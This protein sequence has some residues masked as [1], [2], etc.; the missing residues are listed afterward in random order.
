MSKKLSHVV[1]ENMVYLPTEEMSEMAV[2]NLKEKL[3]I[4]NRYNY[5]DVLILYDDTQI[6]Y[7]G[8]PLYYW[9]N[10]DIVA[11]KIIDRRI[12]GH[13]VSFSMTTTPKP[14]QA[15]ILGLFQESL[16]KGETGL[17]VNAPPGWGKTRT[18]IE[19]LQ[20]LG[21]RAL[22]VVPKSDLVDQWVQRIVD[23]TSLS[24]PEIGIFSGGTA[25]YYP[26]RS[27]ISIGLVHTLALERFHKYAKEFG[28]V[29][30]DEVHMSVPPKTFAPVA[31]LFAPKYRIGASATLDRSDGWEKAFEY[32]IEQVR[33]VGDAST[34]R[35]PAT[36]Y[37]VDFNKSSGPL[38]SWVAGD[39]I[40]TR[41]VLISKFAE[42]RERTNF[43][44]QAAKRSEKSGRRT[45]IISDRTSI[46]VDVY[47]ILTNQLGYEKEEVGFYCSSLTSI[48]GA[49]IRT[50]KKSEQAYTAKHAKIILSTY[51]L[52]STGTDIPDMA[53]IILATPQSKVTQT[54]G[55][56]ERIFDGK[57]SPVVMDIVDSFYEP[58]RTWSIKRHK[59]YAEAEMQIKKFNYVSFLK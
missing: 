45:C 13:K 37:M 14:D 30:F 22:V 59:E 1:V 27:K 21:E 46:L 58:A 43:I 9:K 15:R 56:V 40:K 35:I 34:N 44:A 20:I 26:K 38:P 57:K 18:I 54:K 23:H 5:D 28:V 51:G 48:T 47:N 29:A 11:H 24:V 53:T 50:V 19:M 12:S 17:V 8:V 55:R 41:A 4:R 16:S 49:Q 31:K 2:L 39:K 10:L 6:G 42:N 7:F 32:N 25:K 33:L 36:V 3:A 52:M